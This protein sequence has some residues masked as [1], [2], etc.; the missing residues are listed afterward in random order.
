MATE[1]K[2]PPSAGSAI[3]R[4]EAREMISKYDK[5]HRHDKEKDTKSVFYGRE[6][7][8]RI[9][10]QDVAGITFFLGA[11]P[12]QWAKKDTVQLVLVGTKEDGTLLWPS[13]A[14]S[15][16]KDMPNGGTAGDDGISCPPICPTPLP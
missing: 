2:F 7:I 1:S 16:G 5:E 15:S 13:A 8:E 3:T 9:L 10:K 6:L 12:N 4:E 14:S 11:K